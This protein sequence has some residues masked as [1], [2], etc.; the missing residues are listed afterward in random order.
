MTRLTL[1]LVSVVAA[2]AA[3]STPAALPQTADEQ[4]AG[5]LEAMQTGAR[6]ALRSLARPTPSRV[7]TARTEIASALAGIRTAA[8]AAPRAVGA[9]EAPSM[10]AALQGAGKLARQA[11][12]DAANGRFSG[13]RAKLA[14]AATLAAD[15]LAD[16]GVP[17]ERE[18]ASFVVN[19]DF[20]YLPQFANFSGLSA[21]V[22]SEITEV[23]IGAANRSTA[24]AGEPGGLAADEADSLPI[25][26]MSVAVISDAI[27]RFNSGWC[28]LESGLIT[29]RIRP[30]MPIDRVFTIAFGPKLEPG[31]KILVKF[32]TASGER[33]YA[34]FA[35]R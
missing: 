23:V 19:R 9:L 10:R 16:F 18:F 7:S 31:T 15:A 33:S 6:A 5:G 27:G 26:R 22:K 11:R 35:T 12:A 3:G 25:S 30:A 21:K 17:L 34:V 24:N 14:R 20:A 28:D 29:C 32:R 13:G 4:V 2:L 1:L 8:S